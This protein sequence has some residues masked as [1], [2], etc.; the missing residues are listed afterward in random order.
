MGV[1]ETSRL[2]AR[3]YVVVQDYLR[4]YRTGN[5]AL[6]ESPKEEVAKIFA[7]ARKAADDAVKELQRQ[8]E[9]EEASAKRGGKADGSFKR[10]TEV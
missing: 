1:Y 2:A 7:G 9:E 6:R 3:A 5:A 4:E 8:I 10:L